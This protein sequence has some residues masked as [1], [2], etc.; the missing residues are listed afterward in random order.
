MKDYVVVQKGNEDSFFTQAKKLGY[1]QLVLCYSFSDAKTITSDY[2]AT[3]QAKTTLELFFA[4]LQENAK[5]TQVQSP[6]SSL[7]A[8]GTSLKQLPLGITHLLNVEFHNEKDGTH[9]R[10]S[11]INQV[12]LR[13]CKEKNIEILLS[14]TYLRTQKDVWKYIGRAQL[15]MKQAKKHGVTYSITS[16]A[17]LSSHLRGAKDVQALG[18]VI[19]ETL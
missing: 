10:R 6:F 8:L 9:Q 11:G 7:I 15:N 16:M 14:H 4:V 2:V 19:T 3:L 12:F 1:T 13:I 17:K 18:R 5:S